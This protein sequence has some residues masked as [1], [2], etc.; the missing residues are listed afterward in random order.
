MKLFEKASDVAASLEGVYDKTEV[1][2]TY[3]EGPEE[4]F[5]ITKLILSKKGERVAAAGYDVEG[6]YAIEVNSPEI[7]ILPDVH[8][9]EGNIPL[10]CKSPAALLLNGA[11]GRGTFTDENYIDV[12]AIK[13]GM[14][15][16]TG[17]KLKDD[18]PRREFYVKDWLMIQRPKSSY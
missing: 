16:F 17:M 8:K 2:T 14:A 9:Y 5:E 6:I 10:H 1:E 11:G 12:P 7:F 15:W 13:I 3:E 4:D 18:S